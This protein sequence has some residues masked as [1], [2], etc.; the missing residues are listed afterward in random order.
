MILLPGRDRGQAGQN[1]RHLRQGDRLPRPELPLFASANSLIVEKGIEL[2]FRY[3]G[4]GFEISGRIEG[5]RG[6][7]PEPPTEHEIMFC[8]IH[9]QDGDF[10]ALFRI[11]FGVEESGRSDPVDVT[12]TFAHRLHNAGH[13]PSL[14][15]MLT[16]VHVPGQTRTQR[17][18]TYRVRFHRA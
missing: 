16:A 9:F 17:G 2:R 11:P 3:I 15:S 18:R 5:R 12:W 1:F 13:L 8:R 6:I 4:I 10:G 14:R 7:P